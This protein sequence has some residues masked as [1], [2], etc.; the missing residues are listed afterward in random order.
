MNR[1]SSIRACYLSPAMLRPIDLLGRVFDRCAALGFD[2]VVLP[3]LFVADADWHQARLCDPQRLAPV[4]A[5]SGSAE[6]GLA[7]I[8]ALARARGLEPIM[9]VRLDQL[10]AQAPA[11]G[12]QPECFRPLRASDGPLPDPRR[13]AD[14]ASAA[15]SRF[16][17]QPQALERWWQ[18]QLQQWSEAGLAG[19]RCLWP[20]QVP[21]ASWSTIMAGVREQR[22]AV[23]WVWTPGTEL[24]QLR[25]LAECGFDAGFASLAWW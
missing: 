19:F 17:S 4:L 16:R 2:T 15:V 6:E 25:G 8:S 5:W 1:A 12:S 10:D 11:A 3:H 18:R 21:P 20:Q 13:G 14:A 7:R 9:D 22:P 23:F 24:T